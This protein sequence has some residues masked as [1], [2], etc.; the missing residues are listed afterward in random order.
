MK[1]LFVHYEYAT[2]SFNTVPSLNASNSNEVD[3]QIFLSPSAFFLLVQD[4]RLCKG[5]SQ[6]GVMAAYEAATAN[7]PGNNMTS[8]I[9]VAAMEALLYQDFVETGRAGNNPLAWIAHISR[10]T[11][12]TPRGLAVRKSVSKIATLFG[13]YGPSS[14]TT[15]IKPGAYAQVFQKSKQKKKKS[16]IEQESVDKLAYCYNKAA[17][18]LIDDDDE[19]VYEATDHLKSVVTSLRGVKSYWSVLQSRMTKQGAVAAT[20]NA[21]ANAKV[22]RD[23]AV[24]ATA[25]TTAAA[26]GTSKKSTNISSTP[27]LQLSSVL[28]E[29]STPCMPQM[30]PKAKKNGQRMLNM[31]KSILTR[32]A[33]YYNAIEET[34]ANGSGSS[35]ADNKT[36]VKEDTAALLT[37]NSTLF[38]LTQLESTMD[39]NLFSELSPRKPKRPSKL[40]QASSDPYLSSIRRNVDRSRATQSHRKAQLDIVTQEMAAKV[41]RASRE[42]EPEKHQGAD[43]MGLALACVKRG[44]SLKSQMDFDNARVE[45]YKGLKHVDRMIQAVEEGSS[46]N[47]GVRSSNGDSRTT[48]TTT[49]TTTTAAAQK[50]NQL[51]VVILSALCQTAAAARDSDQALEHGERALSICRK[52]SDPKSTI[53]VLGTIANCHASMHNIKQAVQIHKEQMLLAH[54]TG[55]ELNAL[56]C[57]ADISRSYALV[58]DYDN[59]IQQS[60]HRLELAKKSNQQFEIALAL[61]DLGKLQLKCGSFKRGL[62]NLEQCIH[63]HKSDSVHQASAA[64]EI[65]HVY[66]RTYGEHEKALY[67]HV[68]GLK[69]AK[70]CRDSKFAQAS[71]LAGIAES[72]MGLAAIVAR[73]TRSGFS[74]PVVVQ[75]RKDAL[76]S[77][78]QRKTISIALGHFDDACRTDLQLGLL[79]QATGED[80]KSLTAFQK[81]M[82]SAEQ[83]GSKPMMLDALVE[84]GQQALNTMAQGGDGL[85]QLNRAVQYA[86]ELGRSEVVCEVLGILG[87][88]NL[89]NGNVAIALQHAKEAVQLASVLNDSGRLS[90]AVCLQGMCHLTEKEYGKAVMCFKKQQRAT[91]T[92]G[93]R[94][95]QTQALDGLTECYTCIED[96]DQAAE[97]AGQCVALMREMEDVAGEIGMLFKHGRILYELKFYKDAVGNYKRIVELA[98]R[99]ADVEA[100]RNGSLC[101]TR[102]MAVM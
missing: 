86:K 27:V 29:N 9:F 4:M 67:W 85:V 77:F 62:K 80:E 5:V 73:Q 33:G 53:S 55:N 32:R 69:C 34:L 41:V 63:L 74:D 99:I 102:V 15:T 68:L 64:I 10:A 71:A 72:K 98:G 42:P 18:A 3:Q 2:Q 93:D 76:D 30:S 26:A 21:A 31:Q 66:G 28:L 101:L 51:M 89:A 57:Y 100:G 65:G 13:F 84:Y 40:R 38:S 24:A 79:W 95:G 36:E 14:R 16:K 94:V 92:T 7:S 56:P 61:H 97:M 25:A 23:K 43:E 8:D 35:I 1:R 78:Q 46:S 39:K 96:Y 50:S 12:M 11:T 91:K 70:K 87:R 19:R 37:T 75:L 60:T 17:L 58:Q 22:K 45:F 59:A 81:S 52:M 44:L 54:R 48:P 83:L 88:N 82:V 6:N 49:T 90:G 20:K 47:G